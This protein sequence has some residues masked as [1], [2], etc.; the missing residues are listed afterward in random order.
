MIKRIF[1]FAI[2]PLLLTACTS[3]N[4]P[5]TGAGETQGANPDWELTTR[6]DLTDGDREA[7]DAVNEFSHRLMAEAQAA[8][9]DGEFCVS[10][11]S[12]SIYLGMLANA[13]AG[14]SHSQ[15]MTAL[16]TG[17]I[18]AL[19][20]LCGKLMHY[21]P[22]DENGSSLGIA[23]KFWVSL[24]FEVPS[25]FSDVVADVF[26]APVEYVDFASSATVPSI[27]KW[28]HDNTNGKI[29]SLLDGDWRQY[30]D[31]SMT[32]ANTVYFK[33]DW[34]SRFDPEQS[35]TG[36]FHGLEGDRKARMMQNTLIAG[37]AADD[38]MQTVTL[39]FAGPSVM[40]LYLP[41]RNT[42]IRNLAAA[43]AADA[44]Q[45]IRKELKPYQVT[46]S[47]PSFEK[48]TQIDLGNVLGA[49]GISTDRMDFSPM[50]LGKTAARILHKTSVSIDE[51][52]AE[53]A[54]VTGGTDLLSPGSDNGYPEIKVDFDRPFLY[55]VR[56]TATGAIL[57]AGNVV[58]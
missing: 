27:N 56:N 9:K 50:G 7:V 31:L 41:A 20:S 49:M 45:E 55:I 26:N 8:S 11:L 16:G 21:L 14:D 10:P 23:N 54:A 32:S 22:C 3:D 44:C 34:M 58:R 38:M 57:M 51:E 1:T 18:D 46:L 39:D 43:L 40:E 35:V 17:D 28:V 2:A 25:R 42:D 37:Y 47:L 48:S 19:N 24:V 30:T 36:T 6:L 13:T 15:I 4:A 53:L 29:G 12:V 33:G 52:G 5:D